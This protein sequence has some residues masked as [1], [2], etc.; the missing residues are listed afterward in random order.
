MK[1]RI[2][3]SVVLLSSACGLNAQVS[4]DTTMTIENLV[5]SVLLGEGMIA[6]NIT[7]N[8][9]PAEGLTSP[10]LGFVETENSS[11][12]ISEGLVFATGMA[13]SVVTGGDILST[14]N[15]G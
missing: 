4:V 2:F 10:Q 1:F 12:P 15:L 6:T 14:T 9:L 13:T 5:N 8:G 7:F 3:L 11:F